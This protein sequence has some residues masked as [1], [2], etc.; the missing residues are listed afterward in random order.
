[1][2]HFHA[3]ICPAC[4]TALLRTSIITG[5]SNKPKTY[6]VVRCTQCAFELHEDAWLRTV[7]IGNM[8][9]HLQDLVTQGK[10]KR[11]ITFLRRLAHLNLKNQ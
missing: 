9:L 6:Y 4:D 11:V 8:V 3:E 1:M 2:T 10:E 7:R 5:K